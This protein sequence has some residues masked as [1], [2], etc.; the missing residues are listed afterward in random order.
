MGWHKRILKSD[1]LRRLACRLG[2]LYIRLVWHTS[3]WRIEKTDM[4]ERM[5]AE[6]KGLIVAFWHQ[7]LLMA[8]YCWIHRRL[9]FHMLISHHRDGALISQV[10]SRF[11]IDTVSGSRSKGGSAALRRCLKLLKAGQ[12]VGITPDGP[13]GPRRRVSAG[14]VQMA[15]LSGAPILPMTYGISRRR[16]LGSWDRFV[17]ALPFARATLIWGDPI[18]VPAGLDAAGM[19]AKRLEIE[20]AL[21]DLSDRADREVGTAPIAAAPADASAKEKRAL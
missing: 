2:A 16:V 5:L 15:R 20:A 18:R 4:P 9:P 7:R 14:I 11:G 17:L 12:T 19:E 1:T 3:R 10:V 21:N 8:P 13:R 6:Q